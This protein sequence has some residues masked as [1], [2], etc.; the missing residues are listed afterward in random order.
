MSSRILA[1]LRRKVEALGGLKIYK[2]DLPA[3]TH[4]NTRSGSVQR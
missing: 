1:L 2:E 3:G 4:M